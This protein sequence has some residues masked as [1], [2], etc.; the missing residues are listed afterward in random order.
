[1]F[2]L[3]LREKLM[4]VIAKAFSEL[5][6]FATLLYSDSGTVN[7]QWDDR[8]WQSIEMEESVNQGCLLSSVFAALVLNKILVP[9]DKIIQERAAEC[10][11]RQGPREKG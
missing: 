4:A 11:L 6:P 8:S 9:L 3:I 7:L 10:A 1:M 2:N 5:L